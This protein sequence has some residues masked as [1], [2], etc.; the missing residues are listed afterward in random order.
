[1]YLGSDGISIISTG[2]NHQTIKDGAGVV[3]GNITGVIPGIGT[4]DVWTGGDFTIS[5]FSGVNG[6]G[7]L[8][9]SLSGVV[10][11]LNFQNLGTFFMRGKTDDG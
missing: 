2:F 9:E 4:F 3:D 5:V 6:T 10:E 8:L 11:G 1:M 7:S